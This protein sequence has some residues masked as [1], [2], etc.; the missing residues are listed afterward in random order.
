MLNDV[1]QDVCHAEILISEMSFYKISQGLNIL[2]WQKW[3]FHWST[4][5]TQHK[6]SF[7]SLLYTLSTIVKK[8]HDSIT[9]PGLQLSTTVKLIKKV[10]LPVSRETVKIMIAPQQDSGTLQSPRDL[11]IPIVLYFHTKAIPMR[12]IHFPWLNPWSLLKKISLEVWFKLRWL[13]PDFLCLHLCF[14]KFIPNTNDQI[15]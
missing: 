14:T 13:F 10:L 8:K 4:Y 15:C 5:S 1:M 3:R 6:I 11:I 9:L 2:H 7:I 12:H